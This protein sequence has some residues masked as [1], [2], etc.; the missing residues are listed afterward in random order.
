MDTRKRTGR[1]APV[2][3][4][5][6]RTQMRDTLDARALNLEQQRLIYNPSPAC[7]SLVE[8]TGRLASGAPAEQVVELRRLLKRLLTSNAAE[9]EHERQLAAS[10]EQSLS[11]H[12]GARKREPVPA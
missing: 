8:H 5:Q 4:D 6:L 3:R 1:P 2:T 10:I 9:G 12:F 7:D 11:A